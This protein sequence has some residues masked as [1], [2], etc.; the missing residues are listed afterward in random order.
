MKHSVLTSTSSGSINN[1]GSE[2]CKSLRLGDLS[3][4]TGKQSF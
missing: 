3:N 1:K 2:L 4:G